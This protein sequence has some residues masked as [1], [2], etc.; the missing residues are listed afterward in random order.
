MTY[1]NKKYYEF[2]SLE[3]LYEI[4]EEEYNKMGFGYRSKYFINSLKYI[5]ENGGNEYYNNIKNIKD[6]KKKVKELLMLLNGVGN[7]V[8]DC[9]M[10][11]SLRY[12]N[13]VPIDTHIYQIAQ[14]DFGYKSS[15]KSLT[16]SNYDEV[17]GLYEGLFGKYAGF[18]QLLLFQNEIS[19]SSITP[20]KTKAIKRKRN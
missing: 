5:K 3:E 1:N 18:V 8:A 10:L 13:I 4:K 9:V 20:I 16:N 12:Y 11:Y 6:D 14:R 17:Q 15:N 19:T 2:P 7:K